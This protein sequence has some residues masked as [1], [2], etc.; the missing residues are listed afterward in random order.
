MMQTPFPQT[1]WGE[2][3]V[4]PAEDDAPVPPDVEM[5]LDTRR[6]R[7]I[8]DRERYSAEVRAWTAQALQ[9]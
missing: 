2:F 7:H 9:Q 3:W 1:P 6:W 5:D 4:A 8:I